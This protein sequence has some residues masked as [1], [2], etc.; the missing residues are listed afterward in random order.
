MH[1]LILCLAGPM[2]SWGIQSRFSERDTLLEPSK[3][4]VLGLLCAAMGID[5]DDWETL[6]PFT[7]LEMGVRIDREG[8]A[9]YDYQTA[10]SVLKSKDGKVD[11]ADNTVQSWRYYLADAGFLV[12][13]SGND[14]QQLETAW[15]AL[16][17]P[18]WP[19]SLGRKSYVPS[20]SV[21]LEN[22][23]QK[24]THLLD[25][26][27]NTECLLRN[28]QS[29]KV[30]YVLELSQGEIRTDVPIA[31]FSKRQFGSRRVVIKTESWG[32]K[33]HVS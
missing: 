12:G 33:P 22:G 26:L 6:K 18:M 27:V 30:R 3:S 32:V 10:S 17:N 11:K 14:A 1:T 21:W 5:R 28:R 9:S 20:K 13:L 4:G 15:T 8:I 7:N 19:L 16:K 24:D 2:Q 29:D 25:A 23:L 31:A